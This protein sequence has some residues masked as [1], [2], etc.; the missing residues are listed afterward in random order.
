MDEILYLVTFGLLTCLGAVQLTTM[1][2]Q[3]KMKVLYSQAQALVAEVGAME[4]LRSQTET[5]LAETHAISLRMENVLKAMVETSVCDNGECSNMEHILKE[6]KFI[7]DRN[8]GVLNNVRN[9]R[10]KTYG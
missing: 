3:R 1:H 4:F 10:A 2:Y 7:K 5:R 8:E 9:N 6:F